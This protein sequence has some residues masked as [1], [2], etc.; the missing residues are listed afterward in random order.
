[1]RQVLAVLIVFL[2]TGIGRSDK[3]QDHT[4]YTVL[5]VEYIGNVDRPIKTIVISTSKAG[6]EWYGAT[7]LRRNAVFRS[8]HVVSPPL[9]RR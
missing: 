3:F 1:M 2:A 6:A 5:A 4:E 8:E 9:W 7:I